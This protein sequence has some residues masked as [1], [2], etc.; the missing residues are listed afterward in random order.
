VSLSLQRAEGWALRKTEENSEW[1][2]SKKRKAA[3]RLQKSKTQK[4][5]QTEKEKISKQGKLYTV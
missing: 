5:K 4:H 3:R 1:T 2:V